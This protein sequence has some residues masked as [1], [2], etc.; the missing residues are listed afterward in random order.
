MSKKMHISWMIAWISWGVLLGIVLS[1]KTGSY[2]LSLSWLAFGASLLIMALISRRKK[3]IVLALLGGLLLGLFRGTSIYSQQAGYQ[4]FIGQRVE[5]SG[6]VAEDTAFS[7]DGDQRIKLKN[8]SLNGNEL[9]SVVWVSTKSQLEIKRSDRVSAE[10]FLSE[11]FGNFPAS[12]F[13]ADIK[14]VIKVKNADPP[15]ELRD[16]FAE[17]ARK[18]VSEPEA[19]LGIGFL[20]GQHTTLPEDLNNNLRL[21]GLTHI[22]VASGYNLTILVRLMRRLLAGISKYL[23]TFGAVGLISGFV[24]VTGLSPS[25]SRAGLISLLAITAWYFGRRI[26]PLVLLPFSAAITALVNPSFMWGDLGWYLSFAAF[27]G[28]MILS[29]LLL[30]YFWGKIKPNQ[31]HQIFLE[32]V[33]AQIATLPIIAY[34]FGQYAPLAI[35]ANLLILPLIPLTMIF[36]FFAG[37]GAA[38]LPALAGL[39]G[40][41]ALALLSY[42]TELVGRLAN[43]PLAQGNMTFQ[44]K[45]LTAAYLLI[46]ILSVWL[47]RRTRHNFKQY[48]IIE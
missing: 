30:H 14:R 29:P 3:L 6:I 1:V 10:G 5:L 2:F 28:V 18:A 32:T 9:P 4:E 45:H 42:M 31:F 25:M 37:I 39:F 19:S 16:N 44:L 24:M 21:L 26:H 12:I 34:A 33:S 41:P 48:S 27:G 15:R 43:H 36:T 38:I 22:V 8:V 23:A 47:W 11:G 35:V 13:K 40:F 7:A 20:T 17:K 46:I